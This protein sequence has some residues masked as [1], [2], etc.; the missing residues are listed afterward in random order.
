MT[1]A[2]KIKLQIS[3]RIFIKILN[4]LNTLLR[5]QGETYSWKKSEVENLESGSL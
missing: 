2:I 4:G 3:L 5:G 1:Q